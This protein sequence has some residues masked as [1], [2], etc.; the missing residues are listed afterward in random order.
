MA[1]KFG[2]A[3]VVVILGSPTE[4]TTSIFAETVSS[5]DPT[6]A[7]PLAGI[8]LALPV[9][10]VLEPEVRLAV[11]QEVYAAQVGLMAG[12]LEGAQL[13]EAARR[14]RGANAD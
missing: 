12:V 6:Y 4:E 11:D 10:H 8:A 14:V 5:G 3:N 2:K 13:G 7:G 1:E 9:Y